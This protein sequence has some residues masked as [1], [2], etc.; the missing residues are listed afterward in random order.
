MDIRSENEAYQEL[1]KEINFYNY[2]YHVLDD[3][4]ISDFEF[5]Q[6]LKQ[7]R[8]IEAMH[9]DWI[10]PESP[11]Q[12]SGADPAERFEKISHPANILSLA[13]AFS[14]EDLRN[15]FERISKI[16]E[17]VRD[18][19]FILEPKI[20]GLTVV[21]HYENGIFIQG[22]TR[23]NGEVGEEI[24]KNLRTIK[25]L[26]LKIPVN[27][28]LLEV[29][30][31]LVVRAEAYISKS[32]FALLNERF[33]KLG[34]K[35]YQNPRNTAAGSLR[36]LDS[37]IVAERT[38]RILTYAVIAGNPRTSQ[39][40]TLEYLKELGFP[41]TAILE[42]YTSFEDML[43]KIKKWE[44]YRDS[45]DYEIDGVVIK[46][47]DLKISEDLGF[48]GKDPRGA[49]ALKF[50]AQEVTTRLMDIGVNVGRTGILTPY[51]VLEPAEIGGVIVKQATLHNFDYIVD[52]DIRIGDRVLIKRAGEVIPYII[53]P[54]PDM[55]SGKEQIFS[56]PEICPACGKPVES[57]PDEVAWYCVN[58]SCP[59]QIIRNIEHFVS[60]VGMDI[61][62]L[63][64]KIVEQLVE[65]G[66]IKDVADLYGL[67]KSDLLKLDGFA[68][69]KADNILLSIE[70]SKTRSLSN[71]ITS[72]GIHGIG[73]IAAEELALTFKDLDVL[74]S[75]KKIDIESIDGFGPNS[76]DALENWFALG[77]NRNVLSKLRAYGVWPV[78]KTTSDITSK[79]LQGLKFVIT[80]TFT[81][82]T[83]DGIKEYIKQNGGKV[84]DSVSAKTDYLVL[85]ENPGSKHE[86]AKTLGV[87]IISEL[88]LK[89]I[90]EDEN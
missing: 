67:K 30:E 27:D 72:L 28:N 4:V 83:R 52:K 45:L 39:W 2:R 19:E 38:L 78:N 70:E 20:D 10:T 9:T 64:I 86:K 11:T 31:K 44:S 3:P 87:K 89:T 15:W 35:T 60:K 79:M 1:I 41:V 84:S 69:K 29:P 16:D 81:E 14:E 90:T 24:T 18:A 17:R 71:L 85:G 26:P 13:N 74:S 47:N 8:E 54:I 80:G 76:A 59:A 62:G 55:R 58:N 48:V 49:I 40:E 51:A 22:A 65:N 57:V 7:V 33:T 34:E 6:L 63:G 66:L 25:S 5:D 73:E 75:A 68:E 56:P 53:G 32:D 23:G 88:E 77:E 43:K 42:K 82:F 37:S 61:V 36:L 21:L 50:P 12:R 46:I